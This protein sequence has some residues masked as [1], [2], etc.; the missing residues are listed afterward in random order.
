MSVQAV[1]WALALPVGPSPKLTLV[2]IGNYADEHGRAWPSIDRLAADTSQSRATVQ[3]RLKELEQDQLLVRFAR[4]EPDGR[5]TSDEIRLR[6]DVRPDQVVRRDRDQVDEPDE[7]VAPAAEQASPGAGGGSQSDTGGRVADCDGEGIDLTRGGSHGCDTGRVS[8]VRPREPSLEPPDSPP[9]APLPGGATPQAVRG[10]DAEPPQDDPAIETWLS[11]FRA[12]YPVVSNRPAEVVRLASALDD[13]ERAV[14]LRGARGARALRDRSP[15]RP[16]ALVSPERY[17]RDRALWPEYGRHAP[18]EQPRPVWVVVGSPEWQA[19]S[20]LAAIRRGAMP[21]PTEH[22]G[23]TGAWCPPLPAFALALARFAGTP[24]ETWPIVDR[25]SP[26]WARWTDWLRD[27]GVRL[28]ADRERVPGAFTTH[29]DGS[30]RPFEA[31][32]WWHGARLPDPWPPA[33][34]NAVAATGP[35]G[36]V[37]PSRTSLEAQAEAAGEEFLKLDGASSC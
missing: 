20:V 4:Y 37:S 1:A 15:K 27:L 13:A 3:R 30:G 36:R 31:P 12:T 24:R 25:G 34:G 29:R 10:E 6:L 18:P 8:L 7:A 35:P 11:E 9:K 19:R 26:Q 33:R 23:T 21:R 16:P 28:D 14:A 5:R 22:A 32:V 17:L 2:A